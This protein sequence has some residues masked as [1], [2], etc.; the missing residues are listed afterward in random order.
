MKP[1]TIDEGFTSSIRPKVAVILAT[2][3]PDG[4]IAQQI[5]SIY[6]Q[7]QVDVQIY[8]GDD[9]STT[10]TRNTIR[11][12]LGEGNF[13]EISNTK[14][15]ASG[16]F[17][18]LLNF[19][20][21]QYIAFADQDD[22]WAP[23]KLI[24]HIKQLET[25]TEFPSLSHSN[26]ILMYGR[27]IVLKK[28]ICGDHSFHQLSWQNCVQGCTVVINSKAQELLNR[29]PKDNVA[30]HDWWI[31][32]A[33]SIFGVIHFVPEYDTF[34]RIHSEN[35]I[36]YPSKLKRIVNSATRTPGTVSRQILE[37]LNHVNDS[38]LLSSTDIR[39]FQD[40]WNRILFGGFSARLLIALSDKRA[41]NSRIEDF[42]RRI[43]LVFK[44]P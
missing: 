36:G 30:H 21:E 16:N 35:T 29:L 2:H 7:T 14:E 4:S 32:Q 39:H 24:S 3:Q 44:A 5:R 37:I 17:L 33:I 38:V 23:N 9:R 19:P 20:K 11:K 13:L 28:K 42:W 27:K 22:I 25:S 8:W 15:G 34:Y 12:L 41:R 10:D 6:A 26:S 43:I 18:H 40:Y 1:S 31:A